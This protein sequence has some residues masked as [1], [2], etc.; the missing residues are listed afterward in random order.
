MKFFVNVIRKV[1]S[2]KNENDNDKDHE[3]NVIGKLM[4]RVVNKDPEQNF[5]LV[6][7]L[8]SIFDRKFLE[9]FSME[10]SLEVFLNTMLRLA[11]NLELNYIY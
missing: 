2:A 10:H 5:K 9:R 3:Q 4:E 6:M 1:L 7:M 11:K 8:K